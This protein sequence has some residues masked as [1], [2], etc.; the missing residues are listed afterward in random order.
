MFNAYLSPG[1]S[2]L[3]SFSFSPDFSLLRRDSQ[4]GNPELASMA[5]IENLVVRA[6]NGDGDAFSLIYQEYVDRIYRFAYSR[7]R[8]AEQAEDITQDVFI[9]ALRN[10][11][12]YHYC[13]KPFASWL[14]RI[15]RNQIID[16]QRRANKCNQVPFVETINCLDSHDPEASLEQSLQTSAIAQAIESLPPRQKEVISLRFGAEFSIS[17]TAEA[18][19]ISEG[20]VKKLQHEAI[21]KLRKLFIQPYASGFR[22]N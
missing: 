8:R 20:S 6:Q 19:G 9:K 21:S 10:I 2:L 12:S 18:T 15:A 5:R 4:T 16:F 17:E 11:R 22:F 13:G 14:F 7:L 3:N 1:E